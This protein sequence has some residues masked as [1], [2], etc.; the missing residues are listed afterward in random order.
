MERVVSEPVDLG[1]TFVPVRADKPIGKATWGIWHRGALDW[2]DLLERPRVVVLAEASSG[3]TYEFRRQAAAMRRAGRTAFFT[4]IEQ[5]ASNGLEIVLGTTLA[6][7]L[8]AWRASGDLAWFFLDSVDEAKLTHRT[9]AVA[10]NRFVDALA[11][12][13]DRAR[14]YIS[15]RGTDWDGESDLRQIRELLPLGLG[16]DPETAADPDEELLAP[17]RPGKPSGGQQNPR[18]EQVL[19]RGLFLVVALCDLTAAQRRPVH[20]GA[21][22]SKMRTHLVPKRHCTRRG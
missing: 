6:T 21:R 12:G 8:R 1:R 10:L 18:L 20:A 3:K 2:A 11:E 17:L 5:L 4:P 15:C 13:Y 19:S 9:F 14:V 22:G 16:Q 7:E